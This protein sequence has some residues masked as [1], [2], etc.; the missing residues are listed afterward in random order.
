MLDKIKNLSELL[1]NMGALR[2]K[3]EDVKKAHRLHTS[4]RRRGRGNGNRHGY[5]GRTNYK[6]V[7]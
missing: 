3:M 5:G 4:D 1:S 6:R 2:E 7:H